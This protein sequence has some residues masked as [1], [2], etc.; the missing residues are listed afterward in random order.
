MPESNARSRTTALRSIGA[1][2]ERPI[3]AEVGLPALTV[4]FGL[5]VLR[6]LIP[7]L[8]WTLGDRFGLGAVYLGV[9]ALAV[10]LTAFLA[11]GLRRLLGSGR[12]IAVTAGGL[13]LLRLLMQV[14]WGEPFFNLVLAMVG[15]ALFVMY[16]PIGLGEAQRRNG[17]VAGNFVLGLLL[18][19]ALDTTL[20]SAFLT[21]DPVWQPLWPALLVT[22]LLVVFQ[23]L[24]LAG[25]AA[26]RSA[27]NGPSVTP[28]LS[29]TAW[30]F[31]GPFFFLQLVVL[32]NVARLAAITGW[33]LPLASGWVVFGQIAALAAAV[34][35][36]GRQRRTL[37]PIALISGVVLI[38]I[39]LFPYP[40]PGWLAALTVF[41]GQISGAL[42]LVALA[43]AA[44]S[45]RGPSGFGRL[46]VGNGMGMILLVVLLLG[47]YVVYQMNLPYSNTILEIVSAS[48]MTLCVLLS[49]AGLRDRIGVS[50]RSWLLPVLAVVLL[51][52]SLAGAVAWDEPAPVSGDGF[53]I[54]V[55]TYNLHNGFNPDG[56]LGMEALAEVIEESRPDIVA[57]QEISRGWVI[58]GRVDMLTWL[59][60][61]LDMPYVS[62]PT[63]DPLWG[64]AILSRYPIIEY[65]DHE[66]PPR[67]L[68]ILRGFT[69]AM[70]DLGD[71][72][73][74]R[75]IATHFH[76]L[77]ED[78]EVR[79][80]QSV[81]LVRFLDGTGNT[82]VLGDFNAE[83]AAPEMET[84]RQA[85]LID[86]A[87]TV[88]PS[89]AD[90]F[91]SVDLYQRI[92]YVWVSADL[93]V[94]EVFV[95]MTSAS[96]HL[97]VIAVID[98]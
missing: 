34:W 78:S 58:S 18:G 32:Q 54:R 45:R 30:L 2:A 95:P 15:T 42:L 69:S 98:R 94:S 75:V 43:V 27:E 20:H 97:P 49:T 61:R 96:D 79:Q 13:G 11:G 17:S 40:E 50:R 57:L 88:D 85:G 81:S 10:F 19:L 56:Y 71:G 24:F 59:S 4:T 37:W 86:A 92:D 25:G 23:W 3:I 72:N 65:E 68:F 67:D 53:P 76:H 22:A 87:G 62:G 41:G 73:R 83:S 7:G 44:D 26:S 12:A 63:A 91:N 64:N 52:P 55:M 70:I 47:Y 21:Y 84:L 8:T 16:L 5:Q 46:V 93:R 51:V 35:L 80:V 29:T 39:C 89:P 33:R 38:V 77:E 9:A 90:T 66:L 48:L 82:I 6:V 28:R 36:L 31:I 14:W 1:L 74:L 60:Q